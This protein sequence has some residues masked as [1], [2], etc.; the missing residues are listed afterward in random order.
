MKIGYARVST[1][2][3]DHAM[4]IAALTG[5]GVAQADIFQDVI[6]GTKTSREGLDACLARLA[7]GDVLYVWKLDRL[8]R[9]VL[10]L[11]STI[12][13]FRK[14]GIGFVSLTEGFDITTTMG[15]AMMGML[16]VFA[17][18]ERNNTSERT[19]A[20]LRMLKEQGRRLGPP[21]QYGPA[22]VQ[23][24][25]QLLSENKSQRDI[26]KIMNIPKSTVGRIAL[27]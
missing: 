14:K 15:K 23:E 19:K 24:V 1:D 10:H 25:K 26:A 6:S 13:D 16:A 2:K 12:E 20:K 9:S 4:Q 27:M 18:M 7:P 5:A 21:I 11:S 17:E 3:Q 8:G 22:Q